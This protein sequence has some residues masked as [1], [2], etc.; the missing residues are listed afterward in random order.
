MARSDT[1]ALI[2]KAARKLLTRGGT[3]AITMRAIAAE[4]GISAAGLYRHYR[5]R[6]EILETLATA[7]FERLRRSLMLPA[8][9]KTWRR[10]LEIAVERYLDHAV[11]GPEFFAVMLAMDHPSTTRDDDWPASA[12]LLHERALELLGDEIPRQQARDAAY[13]IVAA[14]HGVIMLTPA[15]HRKRAKLNRQKVAI[16]IVQAV[17]GSYH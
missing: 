3:Q 8:K 7:E 16:R 17:A 11:S 14:T 12:A 2:L 1:K 5:S 6:A 10:Q 4:V 15:N 13:G 9:S